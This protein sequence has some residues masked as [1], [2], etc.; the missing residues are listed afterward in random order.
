MHLGEP[1]R[2]NI[3]CLPERGW[4]SCRGQG[5][6]P[7]GARWRYPGSRCSR[8]LHRETV[9]GASLDESLVRSRRGS[10]GRPALAGGLAGASA[11]AGVAQHGWVV[12]PPFVQTDRP[13][14]RSARVLFACIGR[15]EG[16]VTGSA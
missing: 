6:E 7:P 2:P 16:V 14:F 8:S 1:D 10:H 9:P 12:R 13:Y 15:G 4:P 5:R 3:V 11:R